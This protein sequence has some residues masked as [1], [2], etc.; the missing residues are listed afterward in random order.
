M[1]PPWGF[2]GPCANRWVEA[3]SASE[4]V[5]QGTQLL[6]FFSFCCPKNHQL[7]QYVLCWQGHRRQGRSDLHGPISKGSLVRCRPSRWQ[8]HPLGGFCGVYPLLVGLSGLQEALSPSLPK[9]VGYVLEPTPALS[10]VEIGL[11]KHP[12]GW[13]HHLK[14]QCQ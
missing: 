7:R 11:L 9:L 12:R 5:F 2:P 1:A 8:R 14:L 10:R 3:E 6:L 4:S 13:Q